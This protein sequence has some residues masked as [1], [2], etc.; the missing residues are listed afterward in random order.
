[1]KRRYKLQ[2][3]FR[4]QTKQ[5]GVHFLFDSEGKQINFVNFVITATANITII[6]I[7]LLYTKISYKANK[8]VSLHQM[9]QNTIKKFKH[10]KT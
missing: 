1:M 5:R 3:E 7:L 9:N 8:T 2:S 4:E 10:P 6:K